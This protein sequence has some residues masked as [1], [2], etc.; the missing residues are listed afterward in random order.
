MPAGVRV[1]RLVA[2]ALLLLGTLRLAAVVLHVPLAAYAN[3]YD[4][5]RTSA[6]L[7]LWPD[8]PPLRAAE[9]TRAAPLPHYRRVPELGGDCYRSTAVAVAWLALQLDGLAEA[10]GW[11]EPGAFQLRQLGIAYAL[12]LLAIAVALH[13]S[14]HGQPRWQLAHATSFALVLA[15]PFNTLYFATLY[16]EPAALLALYAGAG[17]ILQLALTR[18]ASLASLSLL[19]L[20]LVALGLSRVQHLLLP[21]WLVAIVG[22]AWWRQARGA[23]LPARGASLAIFVL[24]PVLALAIVL[25]QLRAQAG[26][27]GIAAANRSN[28]V[29]GAL[30]PAAA[31]STVMTRRLGLPEH[32][33]VLEHAN[34]Y[35]PHGHDVEAVCPELAAMPAWRPA[36]AL[37]AEPRALVILVG[38]GLAQT[39]AWRLPYVGELA[40]GA[41]LRLPQPSLADPLRTLSFHG[42]VVLWLSPLLLALWRSA[43]S[44]RTA[45]AP[46]DLLLVLAAGVVAI[47]WATALLGD[48]YAELSRH[49]HLAQNALLLGWAV[50]LVQLSGRHGRGAM[51]AALLAPLLALLLSLAWLRLPLAEGVIDV[52]AAEGAGLRVS[53]W[54]LDP[55]GA[56]SVQ[57]RIDGQ[58]YAVATAPAADVDAIYPLRSSG[59]TAAQ[60]FSVLLPRAPDAERLSLWSIGRHGQH[61]EADAVQLGAAAQ[62][63]PQRTESIR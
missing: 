48:G 45:P 19:A 17:A 28:S 58:R 6:C 38:R 5:A 30:L 21:L 35:M 1:L 4:M 13:R 42:H 14:L 50:L 3:Q 15:D 60:R 20:V 39:G 18:R 55:S 33:A 53:G 24:L 12:L 52:A 57:L 46:A 37:L 40:G 27:P 56:Q 62:A 9:A 41:F 47:G 32:C 61:S 63:H 51:V 8:V 31:D 43:R 25:L 23:A 36:W 16:T 44:W 54:V 59:A 29:T 22:W 11:G 34:W 2:L 26:E 10:A 7:A 49:L